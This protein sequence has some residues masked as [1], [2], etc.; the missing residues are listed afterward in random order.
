MNGEHLDQEADVASRFFNFSLKLL[1]Y[2]LLVQK[3]C[4]NVEADSFESLRNSYFSDLLCF[5]RLHVTSI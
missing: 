2:L 3:G 5:L 1:L 4:I